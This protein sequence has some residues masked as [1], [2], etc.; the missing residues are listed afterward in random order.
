MGESVSRYMASGYPQGT[1]MSVA[2]EEEKKD[3]DSHTMK[4]G[5]NSKTPQT[6][7]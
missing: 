7:P 2:E 6:V 3:W 5:F 4:I 1:T